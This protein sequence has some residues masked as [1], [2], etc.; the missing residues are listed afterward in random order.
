MPKKTPAWTLVGERS[1]DTK[2]AAERFA[3]EQRKRKKESGFNT[4]YEVTMDPSSGSF[5]VREFVY[6]TDNKGRLV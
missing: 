1:F 2:G 6:Q 3:I 4:R 5:R